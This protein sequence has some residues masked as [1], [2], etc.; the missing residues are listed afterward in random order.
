MVIL[1]KSSFQ[2]DYVVKKKKH[3]DYII[4]KDYNRGVIENLIEK[5]YWVT[6]SPL[7]GFSG[8]IFV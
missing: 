3:H 4:F 7:K 6:F 5:K 8:I 1:K 2:V